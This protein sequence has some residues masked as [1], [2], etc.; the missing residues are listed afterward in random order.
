M[1]DRNRVTRSKDNGKRE[2]ETG[3]MCLPAK[4]SMLVTTGSEGRHGTGRTWDSF[5]LGVFRRNQPC[6][7]LKFGL[8]V[9]SAM[10]EYISAILS[11]LVYGNF[12][13][14]AIGN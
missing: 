8:L 12:F 6:Q 9:F 2:A 10:R 7:Y 4:N 3:V 1:G 11:H 5:S 14:A 13:M